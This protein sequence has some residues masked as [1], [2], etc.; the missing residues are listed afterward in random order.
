[1]IIQQIRDNEG[2][3]LQGQEEIR[4]AAVAY[5]QDQLSGDHV[6]QGDDLLCHIP[7]L[8]SKE[9]NHL[10]D[11]FPTMEEVHKVIKSLYPNSTAWFDGFNGIFYQNCWEIIEYVM[12]NTILE[13]FAGFDQPKS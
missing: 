8:I 9:D 2:Q 5:F 13:L 6:S 11:S 12:F 7:T 4:R 3:M 1:M 10:L